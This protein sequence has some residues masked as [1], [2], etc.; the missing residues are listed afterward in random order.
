MD[1]NSCEVEMTTVQNEIAAL[2]QRLRFA[3]L[4]SEPGFFEAVLADDVVIVGDDGQPFFAKT[5]VVEAHQPGT[6]PKFTGVE[7]RPT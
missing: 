5:K 7:I 3:E 1:L 4:G 2:E 6:R